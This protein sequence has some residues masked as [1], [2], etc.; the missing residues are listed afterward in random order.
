MQVGV[1]REHLPPGMQDGEEAD[2]G[3]RCLGSEA[4][5]RRVR[6]AGAE[7][8]GVDDMR[9]LQRNGGDLL[10]E[11]EDEVEVGAVEQSERRLRTQVARAKAW[12]LG[13]WR[14]R[15]ER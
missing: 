12:H 10:R 14:L 4:R 7:Q 6:E 11:S 8:Q 3:P 13:Q 1:K 2:L 9:V 15:Q 5:V